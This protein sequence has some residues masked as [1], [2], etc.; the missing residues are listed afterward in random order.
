LY[1]VNAAI[2]SSL[3][4]THPSAKQ[5]SNQPSLSKADKNPNQ[6]THCAT[7][8]ATIIATLFAAHE[9]AYR[10]SERRAIK[11]AHSTTIPATALAPDGQA[12]RA[13]VKTANS[14]TGVG[15]YVPT[16]KTA[17]ISA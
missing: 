15:S 4:S 13:A 2:K 17:H 16:D 9:C 1:A 7:L 11:A 12:D 6:T 10:A 3:F 8:P 14:A 5:V